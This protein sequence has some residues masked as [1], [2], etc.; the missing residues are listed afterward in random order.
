MTKAQENAILE[1]MRRLKENMNEEEMRKL[2][3]GIC[4]HA[5]PDEPDIQ[6]VGCPY[7]DDEYYNQYGLKMR[8]EMPENLECASC[9]YEDFQYLIRS[10]KNLCKERTPRIM[11]FDEMRECEY[12]Y[13]ET[14][15]K[16]DPEPV[17]LMLRIA[18]DPENTMFGYFFKR[19]YSCQPYNMNELYKKTWRC[20][21][22]RPSEAERKS[23]KWDKAPDW[24]L[25][26]MNE[27]E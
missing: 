24:A 9:L 19:G 3:N 26:G 18:S 13:V 6:C 14:I 25:A 11:T 17:K 12:A 23:W 5:F 10:Y 27:K 2:F 15:D 21:T 16:R 4:Q 8:E 7:S 1:H 22:H 20:W